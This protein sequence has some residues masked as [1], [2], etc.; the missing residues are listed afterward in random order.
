MKRLIGTLAGLLFVSGMA[1]A[2]T[3]TAR[4]ADIRDLFAVSATTWLA[5]SQGGGVY[6]STDSGASWSATGSTAA[7]KGMRYARKLA[8]VGNTV[9]AAT[10][11]GAFKSTDGGQNWTQLT[12]DPVQTVA[13]DASNTNNVM[14]GVRGV[15]ILRST[16]GGSTFSDFSNGLDGSDV[17]AILYANSTTVYAGVYGY[18][19]G[20]TGGVFRSVNGAA[21]QD[22]NNPNGAGA[23]G[24]EKRVTSLEVDG[25]GALYAGLANFEAN[26]GSVWKQS[27]SGGWVQTPSSL[28]PA[29][30]AIHRDRNNGNRLWIGVGYQTGIV[31]SNAG[32][33]YEYAHNPAEQDLFSATT[34]Y[35]TIA[36][37][38][39]VVRA[40]EGAGLF[41]TAASATPAAD[42]ST[43]LANPLADRV[44]SFAIAPSAGSTRYMGVHGSGVYRSTDSGTT[45][46]RV[47][48]GFENK[49][50]RAEYRRMHTISFLGVSPV[51]PNR[52]YA[53]AEGAGGL[54]LT[55]SGT[56]WTAVSES[57][58][59][60][61]PVGTF[62]RAT[63]LL[64]NP[65]NEGEVL[66]SYFHNPLGTFRRSGTS[67]TGTLTSANVTDQPL[68]PMRFV[69]GSSGTVWNLQADARPF[70]SSNFGATWTRASIPN[71]VTNTG[72]TRVLATAL[73]ENPT[74]QA[75]VVFAGNKGVF[76]STDGGVNFSRLTTTGL[77]DSALTSLVYGPSGILYGASR[78]GEYLCSADNGATWVSKGSVVSVINELQISGTSL[79]LVT[80]GS[81]VQSVSLPACP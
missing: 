11:G 14:L 57:G 4:T 68:S 66:L 63:G 9:Y 35:L 48:T 67:W 29:V 69:R 59:S 19:G 54:F 64:V 46:T 71:E 80:D 33:S 56:S 79:L 81:G 50:G 44:R 39:G 20:T 24:E 36:G 55:T 10:S 78:S 74:A 76:R 1:N 13:V 75:T 27:G 70:R 22:F 61:S 8:G 37:V 16:D 31:T 52:V 73:A 41:R 30:S 53:Y 7:R 43:A 40:I 49:V 2:Q 72:F 23:L 12:F 25:A 32:G 58:I 51:N 26:T 17:T 47:N 38:S 15:G 3:Q 18:A 28:G 45:W 21:W 60:N 6:R 65:A 34:A 42:A 62:L 5:A 77:S